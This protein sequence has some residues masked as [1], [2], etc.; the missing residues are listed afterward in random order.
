MSTVETIEKTASAPISLSDEAAKIVKDLLAQQ[1]RD[2]LTLRVY[3]AGSGCSGLQYGMALDENVE[4]TDHIFESNGVKMVVD[5]DSLPYIAGSVVDYVEGP[6]GAGFRVE[7]PNN[8]PSGCGCGSGEGSCGCG[9]EE[10]ESH[11][12]GCGCH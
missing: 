7:N 1:D 3:V 12:G 8:T 11:G 6:E 2:D 4:A 5:E 10:G 9:G